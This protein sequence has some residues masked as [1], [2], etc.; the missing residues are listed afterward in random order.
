MSYLILDFFTF[1]PMQ[2]DKTLSFDEFAKKSLEDWK[3]KATKDL[4]GKP[5]EELAYRTSDGITLEPYYTEENST[6]TNQIGKADWKITLLSSE[7]LEGVDKTV[8]DLKELGENCGELSLDNLAKA[9]GKSAV[10]FEL[11]TK[12]YENIAKLRALRL[13]FSTAEINVVI[14]A[15]DDEFVHNNLVRQTIAALSAII[16]GAK[17]ICILPFNKK[18]SACKK[19]I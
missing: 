13:A 3:A 7:K 6:S 8:T 15:S 9:E 10:Y 16:G 14:P 2:L 1:A 19:E 4:K 5:L 18:D 17:H 12:F 11:G